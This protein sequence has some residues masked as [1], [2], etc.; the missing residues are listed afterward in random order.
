MLYT[1]NSSTIPSFPPPKTTMSSFMATALCPCLGRGTGPD[2]PRTRFHRGCRTDAV[3]PDTA[4]PGADMTSDMQG[5]NNTAFLL[6][7]Y[8][9]VFVMLQVRWR[10]SS[11]TK[12]TDT[13]RVRYFARTSQPK[14][15]RTP[16]LASAHHRCVHAGKG[17]RSF[18][19]TGFDDW[20]I[21]F[22]VKCDEAAPL[23]PMCGLHARTSC[24]AASIL[25]SNHWIQPMEAA[26]LQQTN[27]R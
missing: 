17:N 12:Y 16:K 3:V 4:E 23:W 24:V 25:V 7:A 27:P 2:H 15:H 21:V 18:F 26:I 14:R 1:C 20:L 13:L 11:L 5:G 19:K 22:R 6:Q 8:S 10:E 9:W